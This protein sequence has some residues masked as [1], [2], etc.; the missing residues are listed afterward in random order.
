MN[1]WSATLTLITGSTDADL[2]AGIYG[3]EFANAAEI[4]RTYSGWSASDFTRFKKMMLNVF[5]PINHDFLVRHNNTCANH[6][7]ANWDLCNMASIIAI[8]VLCDDRAKYN[9]A[10]EYFKAGAGN[11]SI[12]NAIYH[13]FSPTLGQWQ[14]EGSQIVQSSYRA[15]PASS[16]T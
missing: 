5:Y 8:G 9:E 6:Y 1:A 7:W 15:T 14:A 2:A 4:M 11:G 3:Y 13:L 12:E 10:V 16:G